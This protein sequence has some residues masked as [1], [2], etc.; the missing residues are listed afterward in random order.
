MILKEQLAES[1]R[2][3]L[4]GWVIW[5]VISYW[6]SCLTGIMV[7]LVYPIALTIAQWY[8]LT[9]RYGNQRPA[10]WFYTIILYGLSF[11]YISTLPIEFKKSV[12][13]TLVLIGYYLCQCIAE[14][15]LFYMFTTWRWAWYTCFNLLACGIW[16]LAFRV[17]ESE[18]Y[19]S[20]G[21]LWRY[22]IIPAIAL[23]TNAVTGYGLLKATETTGE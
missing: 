12:G 7:L 4:L 18:H 5:P 9:Y 13:Y 6:A 16:L 8:V 15:I 2:N 20:D 11:W 17:N 10:F 14:V 3:W 23:L 1:K 22:L 19:P 21:E